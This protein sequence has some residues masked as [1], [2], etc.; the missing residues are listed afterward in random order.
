MSDADLDFLRQLSERQRSSRSDG[1]PRGGGRGHRGRR[2][3]K[4]SKGRKLAPVLAIAFLVA[5]M[6]T[7]GYFGFTVLRGFLKPPDYSGTGTGSVT[8]QIQDGDSVSA[9]GLR[10]RQVDVIKSTTAFVRLAKN[11]VNATSIQPGYYRLRLRMSAKAAL[12]LLLNPA[13]R[14]GRITIPEGR[15]LTQILAT[16]S[17]NTHI[18]LRN[19]Q[20][21]AKNTKALGLP[22]YAQGNLEG[23]LYPFTYDPSPKATA[24]Q[25]LRDMV[26]RFKTVATD[27]D[28]EGQARK[29]HLSPHDVVTVA[30]LVQAESGTS[31]DMPKVARVIY[32]RLHSPQPWMHMLQLDSTVMYG[33]GKYNIIATANDLKSTSPY[34]TYKRAGLPPGAISNPGE[35]ALKA[36]LN[37]VAGTWVYFVTTDPARHITKF[38]A[39]QTEFQRFREELR[40][41]LAH[42]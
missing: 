9:M 17:K 2:R 5:V 33:L 31:D 37:P 24:T 29:V 38:T 21:A 16:L 20:R 22:A 28:L 6:G 10:L 34:N 18:P 1:A 36:A 40:Q 39:S 19:L 23:F 26:T 7:G 3:K 4:S 25:V 11:D 42:G 15:R 12:A 41:N 32:N 14:T 8:V 30:S 13:S 35:A 27:I